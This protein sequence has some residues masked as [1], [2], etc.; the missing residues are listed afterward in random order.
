MGGVA[1]MISNTNLSFLSFRVFVYPILTLTLA[2]LAAHRA[3]RIFAEPSLCF[4]RLEEGPQ[5]VYQR[6]V[7]Y[8]E[9]TKRRL[10]I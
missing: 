6:P 10:Y 4:P 3:Q 5:V 1:N 9:R 2:D 7:C 8:K